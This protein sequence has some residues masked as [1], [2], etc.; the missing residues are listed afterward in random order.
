MCKGRKRTLNSVQCSYLSTH[1]TSGGREEGQLYTEVRLGINQIPSTYFCGSSVHG[2]ELALLRKPDSSP[3]GSYVM[4][5]GLRGWETA[6]IG[7]L[8]PT[9]SEAASVQVTFSTTCFEN[10]LVGQVAS[11]CLLRENGLKEDTLYQKAFSLYL[12]LAANITP[13]PLLGLFNSPALVIFTKSERTYLCFS[14]IFF[15]IKPSP[16]SSSLVGGV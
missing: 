11:S 13:Q 15:L 3:H 7:K 16:G 1:Q 14:M 9:I 6:A 10:Y 12:R 2:K 4:V 8:R 5:P